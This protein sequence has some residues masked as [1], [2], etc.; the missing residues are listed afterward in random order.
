MK[1][2]NVKNESEATGEESF[3]CMSFIVNVLSRSPRTL[4]N[5]GVKKSTR[6]GA[7]NES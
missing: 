3:Q 2:F 1:F 7:H 6:H 4:C 5:I